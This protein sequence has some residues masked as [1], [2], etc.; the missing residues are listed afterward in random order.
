MRDLFAHDGPPPCPVCGARHGNCTGA[1]VYK[2]FSWEIDP[3]SPAVTAGDAADPG[4]DPEPVGAAPQPG[5]VLAQVAAA[6][7]G[8]CPVCGT[9][10]LKGD[11]IALLDTGVYVHSAC[12]EEA[13]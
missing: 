11:P 6:K 12:A 9:A 13:E 5:G 4:P 10:W 3:V 8:L 2:P 1:S 7:Q